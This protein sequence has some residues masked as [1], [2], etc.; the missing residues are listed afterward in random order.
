M[1]D[2]SNPGKKFLLA[3]IVLGIGAAAAG[4]YIQTTQEQQTLRVQVGSGDKVAASFTDE[5]AKM[6]QNALTP[7]RVV[8]IAP[9]LDEAWIPD[10]KAEDKKLPRYTP[11][12]FA[13]RLWQV[14]DETQRKN[15]VRDLLDAKSTS[16]YKVVDPATNESKPV[17][18]SW[19]FEN[20]MLDVLGAVNA[21][22]VDSDADGFTN[23]EEFLAGTDPMDAKSMPP[24]ASADGVKMIS[25]GHKT[26]VVH[27][28][29]LS[30]TSDFESGDI[31]INVFVGDGPTAQRRLSHRGLSAGK[32]FGLQESGKGNLSPKRFKVV[33]VGEEPAATPGEDARKYVEVEDT[34]TAVD[35]QKTIRLYPGSKGRRAIKDISVTL[36]MTAGPESGKQLTVQLGQEFA[37]P[38]FPGTKCKLTHA[39]D[40]RTKVKV[41]VN[42]GADLEVAGD[43]SQNSKKASGTNSQQ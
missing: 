33:S 10:N 18:N 31:A 36:R 35:D 13:P 17:P 15:V 6:K 32:T 12:F 21:M 20:G 43:G 19:F 8:D 14:A 22:R 4:A 42:G 41:S 3:G 1:A 38:G 27:A 28:L 26:S 23:A 25:V 16:L 30:T 2:S 24:F 7:R 34:Y 40:K 29:E 37:V 5:A 39:G 11:I 9:P